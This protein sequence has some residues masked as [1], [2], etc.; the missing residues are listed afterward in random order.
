MTIFAELARGILAPTDADTRSVAARVAEAI[1]PDRT[2][3]LSGDLGAGKTTFVKGLASAWNIR[4]AVTSPS[5]A[6]CNM[7]QGDRLLVHVD[8]YR[9]TSS[10]QWESLMIDEFLVSPWCMVIEWPEHVRD[11]IAEDAIWISMTIAPS[12]DRYIRTS[13]AQRLKVR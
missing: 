4:E 12:G 3:A 10:V 8:A 7:H 1:D 5:F 13:Q 9:L 11:F 2:L 6:V